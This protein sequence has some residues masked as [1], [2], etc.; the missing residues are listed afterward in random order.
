MFLTYIVGVIAFLS[1]YLMIGYGAD[2]ICNLI[3]FAYPA[4]AS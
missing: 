2:F 4:Y 3:G 1:L